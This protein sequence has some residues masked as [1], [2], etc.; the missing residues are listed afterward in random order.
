MVSCEL[1][2]EMLTLLNQSQMEVALVA[3]YH[4]QTMCLFVVLVGIDSAGSICFGKYSC[5]VFQYVRQLALDL[6]WCM[7]CS[8]PLQARRATNAQNACGENGSV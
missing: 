2:L 8:C 7:V 5:I 4:C 1:A 3:R 6:L